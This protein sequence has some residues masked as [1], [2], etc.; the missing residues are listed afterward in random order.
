ME[1]WLA[2]VLAWV[3][4]LNVLGFTALATA[5]VTAHRTM[6]RSRRA[7]WDSIALWVTLWMQSVGWWAVSIWTVRALRLPL[8][9]CAVAVATLSLLLARE[10]VK[11]IRREHRSDGS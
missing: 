5:H 10:I 9:A 2:H 4:A 3:T 1:P 8:F 6:P 11:S 7:R